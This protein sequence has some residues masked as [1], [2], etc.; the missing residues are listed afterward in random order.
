MQVTLQRGRSR[1]PYTLISFIV[2]YLI[3][4]MF[5][6]ARIWMDDWHCYIH[7]HVPSKNVLNK[8]L[9]MKCW[10]LQKYYFL[11]LGGGGGEKTMSGCPPLLPTPPPLLPPPPPLPPAFFF[12]RDRAA[13]HP[14][15]WK[16]TS[17]RSWNQRVFRT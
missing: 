17:V 5:Y 1:S 11:L 6:V 13:L 7:V 12:F 3:C 16:K 15:F 2:D 14:I 10:V 9:Q 4:I 8:T